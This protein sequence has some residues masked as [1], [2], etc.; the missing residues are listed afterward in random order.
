[1]VGVNT[2]AMVESAIIGR[3]VHTWLAP[4]WRDTQEGTPHF[5]LIS[6]FGG[7]IL[8][9]AHSFDEHAAQ[10]A[11]S[12]SENGDGRERRERFLREFVRPRGLER[13]A[14][15]ILVAAIDAAAAAGRRRPRA[16]VHRAVGRFVLAPV[17]RLV[18]RRARR[19][20]E[21]EAG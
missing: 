6:R 3:P 21:A 11:D 5:E 12:M 14:A 8:E 16:D 20:R 7:G 10:L 2:S 13:P 4:E 9:I 19:A 17:V 1:V 18:A 15:P